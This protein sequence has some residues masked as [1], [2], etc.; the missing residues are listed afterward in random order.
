V[1]TKKT[2]LDSASLAL[3]VIDSEFRGLSVCWLGTVALSRKA[4]TK[5]SEVEAVFI[6]RRQEGLELLDRGYELPGFRA[7]WRQPDGVIAQRNSARGIGPR[8]ARCG[9]EG[10]WVIRMKMEDLGS[11]RAF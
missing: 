2:P 9:R 5:P 4:P 3:A 8:D 7:E 10:N 11:K 6:Q 1:A